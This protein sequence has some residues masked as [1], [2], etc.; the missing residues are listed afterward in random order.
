MKKIILNKVT[1]NFMAKMNARIS[2][3]QKKGVSQDIINQYIGQVTKIS[4]VTYE[5]KARGAK[6]KK[7]TVDRNLNNQI[8]ADMEA[9]LPKWK[10]LN[11]IEK[12]VA[13][14]MQQYADKDIET[15]RQLEAKARYMAAV[16][17]MRFRASS[18]LWDI[19][20]ETH[21]GNK[22]DWSHSAELNK[23][24]DNIRIKLN[25]KLSELA[26][27][28]HYGNA[29]AEEIWEFVNDVQYA[30]DNKKLPDTYN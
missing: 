30:I 23:L 17:Q 15:R 22:K 10:D 11:K 1:N 6:G 18:D 14:E 28:M 16:E 27:S 13:T 7:L 24:E 9:Q 5:D 26:S 19:W 8:M 21:S 3:W 2:A 4:G 25:D 12:K 20:Y 29:S